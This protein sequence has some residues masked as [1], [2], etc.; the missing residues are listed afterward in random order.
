MKQSKLKLENICLSKDS[1]NRMKMQAKKKP[2]N[3]KQTVNSINV[4]HAETPAPPRS[5]HSGTD[6]SLQNT[7]PGP[8]G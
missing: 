3:Y 6:P 1:I 5:D 8:C 4:M 7:Q 2:Q